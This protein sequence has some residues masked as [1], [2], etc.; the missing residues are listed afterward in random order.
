MMLGFATAAPPPE[1]KT[2]SAHS[3][4]TAMRET[5]VRIS[6]DPGLSSAPPPQRL[7]L[8]LSLAHA[9]FRGT[10]ARQARSVV[11]EW[12]ATNVHHCGYDAVLAVPHRLSENFV[13]TREVL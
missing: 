2:P 8:K 3:R 5:L 12:H 13:R 1:G 6:R 11:A 10:G 4:R 7:V 9:T